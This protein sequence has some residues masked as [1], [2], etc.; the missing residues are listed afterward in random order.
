MYSNLPIGIF[1][2]GVGGLTV[3][4]ELLIELP[5]EDFVYFGDNINAPY[6]DRALEDIRNLTLNIVEFLI[7]KNCKMLVI[8]CNTITAAAFDLIKLKYDVPVIEVISNGVQATIESTK[9]KKVSVMATPFTVSSNIYKD[10]INYI[11]SSI[12]V[13]QIPCVYLCPMIEEGF[14]KPEHEDIL[15]EYLSHIPEDDDTLILG[16]THYPIVIDK[17]RKTFKHS[18]VDPAVYTAKN[19]KNILSKLNLL[20]GNKKDSSIKIFSSLN[21]SSFTNFTLNI[22]GENIKYSIEEFVLSRL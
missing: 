6:G 17:I 16:C 19:T 3:L 18:I 9:N 11:D 8:A 1:D 4:K 10:S 12:R 7:S 14:N 21:A 13:T 5:N 2:S 15:N 20:N 22:L